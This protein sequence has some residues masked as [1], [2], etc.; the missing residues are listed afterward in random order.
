MEELQGKYS[1]ATKTIEHQS[2]KIIELQS[3]FYETDERLSV[4]NAELY[5]LRNYKA[6]C[7]RE[8]LDF[9]SKMATALNDAKSDFE[10]RIKKMRLEHYQQMTAQQLKF[11][12]ERMKLTQKCEK[13]T[14]ANDKLTKEVGTLKQKAVALDS[15]AAS[16]EMR[17]PLRDNFCQTQV[18]DVGLWDK[19]DGWVMPISQTARIRLL[20]RKAMRF[21][22]CPACRG[23]GKYVHKVAAV[24]RAV[25]RGKE[26]SKEMIVEEDLSKWSLP[27]ECVRFMSNLPKT[28]QAFR[29]RGLVWTVRCVYYL[30]ALKYATDRQDDALGYNRQAFVE[31]VIERYLMSTEHRPD[32]ELRMYILIRS[33]REY[34]RRHPM[35]QLFAR[36]MGILDDLTAEEYAIINHQQ[37]LGEAALKRKRE[38]G[39]REMGAR[40]RVKMLRDAERQKEVDTIFRNPELDF[41][42]SNRALGND[43]LSI[44][45]YARSCMLCA[46]YMGVYAVPIANAKRASMMQQTQS[47]QLRN[48]DSDAFVADT[49]IPEVYH[50]NY[51]HKANIATHSISDLTAMKVLTPVTAPEAPE[52][53]AKSFSS[54]SAGEADQATAVAPAVKDPV[55][56]HLCVGDKGHHWVPMDRAINVVRHLLRFLSVDELTTVY[57]ALE[58]NTMFLMENG[59]LDLPD[60]K[61]NRFPTCIYLFIWF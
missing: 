15:L 51:L 13:F 39:M 23:V 21:A 41:S 11:A 33:L 42:I 7:D 14:V 57:H 43:I 44:T 20:W 24:L 52:A 56:L 19:Q 50:P 3:S 30:F 28:A 32:A 61:I 17:R 22:A 9:D 16:V 1:A 46:P 37:I 48:P 26:P 53:A 38:E 27:D 6:A 12:E 10:T 35:L 31:F 58:C 49:I 18:T 36:F 8:R 55:P 4:A 45:L 60:G 2:N 29:P 40:E 5:A 34:Y 47:H 54:S 25:K 59:T